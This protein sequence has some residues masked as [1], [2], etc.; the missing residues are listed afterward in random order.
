MEGFMSKLRILRLR[1]IGSDYWALRFGGERDDFMDMVRDLKAHYVRWNPDA[2][3]KERGG[4]IVSD[5]ILRTY[6]DRFENY[7]QCIERE[8]RRQALADRTNF[9]TRDVNEVPF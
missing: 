1:D 3:G 5:G 6:R 2:F 8:Q 7:Q 4:W 9:Y